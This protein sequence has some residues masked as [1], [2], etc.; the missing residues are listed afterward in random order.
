MRE[1]VATQLAAGKEPRV[2]F[3]GVGYRYWIGL[4]QS[5]RAYRT[6]REAAS[7]ARRAVKRAKEEA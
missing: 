3:D 5:S 7:A 6:A 1:T 2:F 4:H